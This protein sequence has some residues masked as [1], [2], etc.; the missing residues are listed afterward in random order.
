MQ[1]KYKNALLKEI[2]GVT[3]YYKSFENEY[4]VS[5]F[6]YLESDYKRR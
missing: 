6:L 2:N 4:Y 5:N 1:S 3:N